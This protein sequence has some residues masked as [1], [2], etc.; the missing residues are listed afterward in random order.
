MCIPS[1]RNKVTFKAIAEA[2]YFPLARLPN[3]LYSAEPVGRNQ[4]GALTTS[5]LEVP[6]H[7]NPPPC[8][9][10]HRNSRQNEVCTV[11]F[12]NVLL[13]TKLIVSAV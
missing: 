7:G 13:P 11:I 2:L 10:A 8:L 5:G 4:Q 12:K 3:R 9:S 6:I 1:G